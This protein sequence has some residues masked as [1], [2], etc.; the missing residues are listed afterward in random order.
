MESTKTFISECLN[1]VPDLEKFYIPEDG[2]LEIHRSNIDEGIKESILELLG[3]SNYNLNIEWCLEKIEDYIYL[4]T[5]LPYVPKLE[6][7]SIVIPSNIAKEDSV[8][9]MISDMLCVTYDLAGAVGCRCLSMTKDG[10]FVI[11]SVIVNIDDELDY[12]DDF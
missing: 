5:I 12:D 3:M 6:K 9:L 11:R 7:A 4:R 2:L 8:G 1:K 10:N